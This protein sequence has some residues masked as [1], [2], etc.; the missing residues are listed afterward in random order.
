MT[1]RLILIAC[2]ALAPLGGCHSLDTLAGPLLTIDY[3]FAYTDV[4]DEKRLK[5][6]FVSRSKRQICLGH[7]FWPASGN[8]TTES[9]NNIGVYL[10]VQERIYA[11]KNTDFVGYCP[12][13][14]CYNPVSQGE[15]RQAFLVYE[16]FGLPEGSYGLHKELKYKPQPFWC[17]TGK[18]AGD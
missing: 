8:L 18:F 1:T 11:C 2:L 6:K 14:S 4:P 17:D 12:T 13:K 9:G 5:L 16:G 15:T 7:D 3:D 10:F